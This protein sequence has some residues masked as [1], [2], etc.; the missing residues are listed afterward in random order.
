VEPWNSNFLAFNQIEFPPAPWN[1][2]AA[3]G[4]STGDCLAIYFKVTIVMASHSADIQMNLVICSSSTLTHRYRLAWTLGCY[5]AF[6]H[7]RLLWSSTPRTHCCLRTWRQGDFASSDKSDH[8]F[9]CRRLDL[10]RV[11]HHTL[12]RMAYL[13]WSCS[14]V[15]V[16]NTYA[17]KIG[18]FLGVRLWIARFCRWVQSRSAK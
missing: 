3:R 2:D 5:P 10:S 11:G 18:W 16:V 6:L 14:G 13:E 7:L 17:V 12:G 1:A 8:A 4:L 15:F 9:A